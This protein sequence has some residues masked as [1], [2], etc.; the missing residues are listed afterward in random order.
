MKQGLK[1]VTGET[2][3]KLRGGHILLVED[4]EINQ[5]VAMEIL[6]IMGLHVLIANNGD[7]AL[8]MVKRD[9]FD[10]I[11]MDIQMPG[12]DG[13]E[14][15]IQIRQGLS[16]DAEQLPIIAMTAN[17]MEADRRKALDAG[18]NDYVSKPVDVAKLASVLLHW[19]HPLLKENNSPPISENEGPD[20]TNAFPL[21]AP[22]KLPTT[23]DSLDMTAALARLGGNK[24]LYKRLLLMFHAGH[25]HTAQ[26]IRAALK[27]N[28]LE[29]ARRL[30][31]TLKGLAGTMGADELRAAAKDLE[32]AI[33]EG[34]EAL[35][36]PRLQQVEQKLAVVMASI[37]TLNHPVE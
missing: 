22:V 9:H 15:T 18:L 37:S 1:P 24:E 4:N 31:H 10:A 28:D 11:L 25:E 21:I 19:V 6:K 36:E 17:A 7:E 23:L 13:Y 29:L 33:G 32:T 20:D 34:N 30:A 14:T 2:L 8:A 5:R 3:E 12:M 27:S 26:A 35:F 16:F